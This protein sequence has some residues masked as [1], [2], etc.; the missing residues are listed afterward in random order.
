MDLTLSD[1]TNHGFH[2]CM[3]D[4]HLRRKGKEEE[5]ETKG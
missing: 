5:E 4:D 2:S 3:T 1:Y